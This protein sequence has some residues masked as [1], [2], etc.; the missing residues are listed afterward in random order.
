MDWLII[1]IIAYF[2]L[3]VVNVADKFILKSIIPGAKTYTFL[4]GA[5]G[6][7]V[8]LIAP[9]FLVWPGLP[10]LL[11]NFLTG[12]FFAGGLFYL[13]TALKKGEASRV[14]TLVGGAVPLFTVL[15]SV[16][17]FKEV[18][19][20][21]QWIAMVFLILGTMVIS[22]ITGHHDILFYIKRFLQFKDDNKW[23]SF[24]L[25]MVAALMFALF[26]VFTK[27]AY[28]QQEFFSA[29]IWIRVGTFL[30]VLTLLVKKESRDEIFGEIKNSSKQKSNQFIYFGTQGFGA[31]GTVLQNYAVSLGSVALVTSLQGLQYGLLLVFT[32]LGSILIPKIVKEDV[33]Q[34]VIIQKVLSIALIGIGLYFLAI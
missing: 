1:S 32:A 2:I 30:T 15:L 20:I 8:F 16:L 25:A 23:H 22:R 28:N 9:W 17:F 5:T 34:S 33:S 31:L 21:N 19:T 12:A 10:L 29:F 14:F 27:Y 3:A 11:L 13:Y 6:I 24:G 18:F 4:V 26:W 7:V